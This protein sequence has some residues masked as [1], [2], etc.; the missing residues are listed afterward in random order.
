M[1]ADIESGRGYPAG[2]LLPSMKQIGVRWT[3]STTTARRVLSELVQS[4]YARA[5]ST[6]GHFS[7]GPQRTEESAALKFERPSSIG[8]P[9]MRVLSR[10]GQTGIAPT[11]VQVRTEA[12]SP[13]AAMALGLPNLEMRILVRRTLT[14]DED[15]SPVELK[16]SYLAPGVGE[17]TPLSE[18]AALDVEWREALSAYT[19]RELLPA[20]EYIQA[21]HPSDNESMALALIPSSCVLVHVALTRDREGV[22][23]DY[24]VTV[25][26]GDSTRMSL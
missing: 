17:D 7:T 8:L 10:A 21:R 18:P 1:I 15:K 22:P 16:T 3:V 2:A 5:D 23:V 26:P 25:W 24:S 19:D 4:G 6:R 12:A 14:V 20:M 13:D 11:V 9:R